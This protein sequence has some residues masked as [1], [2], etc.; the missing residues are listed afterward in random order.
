M[1]QI[2]MPAQAW[3]AC[4]FAAFALLGAAH[5]QADAAADVNAMLQARQYEAALGKAAEH[6]KKNPRDP[7]MRFL[8]GLA[9][10]NMDRK[11]EAAAVFTALTRDYP[12]LAEPYNNLAVI[13]ASSGRYDDAL[14]ALNKAI[15]VD[16]NYATAYENLADL[17]LQL[18]QQAYAKVLQVN[19]GNE[20]A[21]L[22]QAQ[23]RK[24]NEAQPATAATGATSATSAA[25][26]NA[27]TVA[28]AMAAPLPA[29]TGADKTQAQPATDNGTQA[30]LATLSGWAAAWSA[31]DVNAYLNF[32]A[33]EF[34]TPKQEP[35]AAW[36]SKRRAL[37][38]SKAKID[39][40][41]ESPQ[42]SIEDRVATVRFRQVY[43]SD[44][45][46]SRERKTLV[47]RRYEDNWKIVEERT[48]G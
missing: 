31:R 44:N 7:Q 42:V 48:G 2:F 32:Y 40:A 24:L 39:V 6:L 28:A 12:K 37:I 41:A 33:P 14:A 4:V 35:R 15:Q 43:V 45:F 20:A 29:A 25:A 18:A 22:R 38:E 47:L 19:P 1:K 9:L 17:H 11:R 36:E 5:A 13:H 10:T 27:A 34:R 3:T 21:R 30:V 16:P 8:Q 46:T 26:G 23:L